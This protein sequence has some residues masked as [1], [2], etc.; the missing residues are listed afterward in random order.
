MDPQASLCEFCLRT[1]YKVGNRKIFGE[2]SIKASKSFLAREILVSEPFH[3]IPLELQMSAK[4]KKKERKK[5]WG[6]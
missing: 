2:Q 1:L 6:K 5:K 4:L 3:L